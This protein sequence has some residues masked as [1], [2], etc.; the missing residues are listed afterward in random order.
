[1]PDT[2]DLAAGRY[3][4]REGPDRSRKGDEDGYLAVIALDGDEMGK[5]ISGENNPPVGKLLA[6]PAREYFEKVDPGFLEERRPM[7]PSFHLQFSEALSNFG[8]YAAGRIVEYHA[9]RLIYAGGDDVLALVPADR[10]L[11]CTLA[12][13]RA[14]RGTPDADQPCDHLLF[15][16]HTGRIGFLRLKKGPDYDLADDY[17]LDPYCYDVLMPGPAADVSAGVAI[18]H[19][20]SPI[21]DLVR[22]AQQ[23]EKL[24]KNQLGRSAIALSIYKRSGEILE[25]GCPWEQPPKGS[26]ENHPGLDLLQFLVEQLATATIEKR[27]PHKL[28][29]LLEPYFSTAAH[30]SSTCDPAFAEAHQEII[31]REFEHCQRE[32]PNRHLADLFARYLDSTTI[33]SSEDR[34]EAIAR[35]EHLCGLLR[36]AGWMARKASARETHS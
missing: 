7:N 25:W 19:A 4:Q 36:T 17:G 35:L 11:D 2:H 15:E 9:G 6:R 29:A 21:Q 33:H 24:A 16:C 18:G 14:F 28:I 5:W 20:K 8:L 13:R 12:L 1:M 26:G 27:F 23:A 3:E 32:A 31:R 10:A 30:G 22:Q 34:P